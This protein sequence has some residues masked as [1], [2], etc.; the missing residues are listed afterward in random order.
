MNIIEVTDIH[1]RKHKVDLDALDAK[2]FAADGDRVSFSMLAMD[3]AGGLFICDAEQL[4]GRNM[5]NE[6]Y[7]VTDAQQR[8]VERA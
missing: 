8:E 2:H 5:P 6:R 7:A 3:T 4:K 1:G